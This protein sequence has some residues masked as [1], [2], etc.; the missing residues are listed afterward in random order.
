MPLGVTAGQTTTV[1]YSNAGRAIS[2]QAVTDKPDLEVDWLNDDNTLTLVQPSSTDNPDPLKLEDFAT[3]AAYNEV[4]KSVFNSP[5]ALA[6]ERA[7][8]TY[9]LAF[10]ADGSFRADDVPPGKYELMIRVSKPDKNQQ[11][12]PFADSQNDL[13]SLTREVVVPEGDRPFDL[14][15]L[16]VAMK[17]RATAAVTTPPIKFAATTL[18]GKTV[19]LQQYQGRYVVL[20]FWSLWSDRSADELK[21]LQKLQASLGNNP[22]V[23]FLGVNLGDDPAAVARE[24][25]A[26]GYNWPQA[27][28]SSTNLAQVAAEFQVSSLPAICL[29]DPDGRIASRDLMG[30]RLVANVERALQIK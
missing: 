8:R 26:R 2:G 1:A 18:D 30:E 23:A 17:G 11:F 3:V 5:A 29:I 14:G 28:V 7:A 15:T 25:S 6:R 21:G 13:G 9:V 16:T 10:D 19:N 20:A 24:T 12:S 22:H 4:R 27:T